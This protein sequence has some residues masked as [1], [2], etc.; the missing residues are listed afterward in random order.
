MKLSVL[1]PVYNAENTITRLC[2]RLIELYSQ[3]FN[4]EIVLVNDGSRDKTDEVCRKIHAEHSTIITYI[5]LSKNFGEHSALMAGLNHITGDYCVMM[6]DDFQNPP[7]EIVKLIDAVQLGYDVVYSSYGKKRDGFLRNSGS[8]LHNKIATIVLKKPPNLYLSSFKIINRFLIDEIRKYTAA[9]PYIDGIILRSTNN[10]GTAEVKHETRQHG[11]SG[12]TLKKLFALGGNMV[13]NYSMYPLRMIGVFGLVM[14]VIGLGHAIHTV[15]AIVSPFEEP[16]EYETLTA[17]IS[18]FRGFQ[19]LAI[20]IVG[21]YV[22][23]IY[24][25]LNKDPQFIVREL[26]LAEKKSAA[27][28][29]IHGAEVLNARR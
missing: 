7:E 16:T 15:A 10:I 3:R 18:F 27:L 29:S 19:L 14:T 22:G 8:A 5:K 9:A 13:V 17:V 11:A 23:R 4:L 2:N 24:L 25:S 6:D 26:V 12:Y 20:S 1:I 21:E 28:A